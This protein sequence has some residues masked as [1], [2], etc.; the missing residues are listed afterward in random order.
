MLDFWCT[1]SGYGT[2]S[3][4]FNHPINVYN[5]FSSLQNFV[6]ATSAKT[7]SQLPPSAMD[8]PLTQGTQADCVN[9]TL[10]GHILFLMAENQTLFSTD[11]KKC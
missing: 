8:L 3:Q 10:R 7:I 9:L 4:E 6:M 2:F 11:E 5:H 1:N